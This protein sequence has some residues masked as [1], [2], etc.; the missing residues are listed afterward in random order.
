[1]QALRRWIAA[2][3]QAI[4]MNDAMTIKTVLKEAVPEFRPNTA[5]A[6]KELRPPVVHS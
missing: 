3:E 1:M 6:A 5:A 2:L 4:E